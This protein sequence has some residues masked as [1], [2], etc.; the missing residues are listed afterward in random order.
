M[1]KQ[2]EFHALAADALPVGTGYTE[3]ALEDD[4]GIDLAATLREL[5]SA[6]YRNW[7]MILSIV[8]ACLLLGI[9]ATML[10][11]PRYLAT[12]SI[13]V[14]QVST[15]VLGTEDNDSAATY[16][17]ADRFLQTQADLLRSQSLAEQVAG[18]LALAGNDRFLIAM[19]AKPGSSGNRRDQ[20]LKLLAANL[21][22]N[23][24][25]TSRIVDIGFKSPDPV[26]AQRVANSFASNFITLNIKRKF[27][28]SAYARS[29]LQ[30]QLVNA[31]QRLE[32]SER[33][34]L[35]YSRAVG[36]IDASAGIGTNDGG[37]ATTG[38]RSLVTSDL[39]A[40]NG[41]YA[42]AE[43]A[44]V[45]AQ[46]HWDSAQHTP[47]FSLPEVL[48]NPAYNQLAQARAQAQAA[49][50]QES[51]RHRGDF[52]AL[53]QL[54]AQIVSLD[55]QI[56][57]LA[58][59]IRGS[60]ENQYR[61]TSKQEAA[62][63]GS[64]D[65]LK[66]AT[67]N[68][69]DKS[70]RYNILKRETDTN[71]TMYDGLLQRYKEV[72][73]E[74]GISIN[75]I[76][77]VDTAD[78]PNRPVSPRLFV[79]LA[80]AILA[81]LAL[82]GATVFVREKF[83]DAVRSPDDVPRKLGL[84]LLNTVPLLKSG[85]TPGTA[86]EDPRSTLSESYA[87]LRTALELAHADG[88]PGTLV[89]TSCRPAEGKSTSAYAV[90]RDFARTGKRVVLIDGDLRR[91]SL[92]RFFGLPNNHGL[93]SVLARHRPLD[94]VVQATDIERLAF[95]STGP[96]PPNP[97]E[98]LS[99]AALKTMLGDLRRD[100][101][102]VIIDSPPVLGL[103]DAV[104]LAAQADAVVF[105]TEANIAHHGQAKAA[106]RR[107]RVANTPILG[108]VLTKFNAKKAGY[109]YDYGYYAYNYGNQ[110]KDGTQAAHSASE[111]T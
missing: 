63:S 52:P 101:D 21:S 71:R 75:N 35:A 69:Q 17:D 88:L 84:P 4:A 6:I 91:P 110:P 10:A 104:I 5:W 79:N 73:A 45:A 103:A 46:Q 60:I 49:Y 107:L 102:L 50:D 95:L 78:I 86:L 62:L 20:V 13:Q 34:T 96:L 90:A 8:G 43:A 36:L 76:S 27:D 106:I 26:L 11:T 30:D 22:I 57:H 93:T 38:P 51:Q 105:V 7:P 28:Q 99:G 89:F 53:R 25:R 109:G 65:K 81:G 68:E 82:A 2:T 87:A 42:S 70:V 74:A 80:I 92:H 44:R 39:V 66:A 83:D 24:P 18:S 64:V 1:N 108:A 33:A 48:G 85:E 54:G 47:V 23:L 98:L 9:L 29:F 59:S 111:P 100:F 40:L 77:L 19:H 72:S 61:I 16:Q 67:L 58:E 37:S 14:D 3:P 15:K 31:K 56:T 94:A 41:A 12:A 32:D 97:A 55:R